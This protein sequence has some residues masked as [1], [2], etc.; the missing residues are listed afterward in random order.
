MKISIVAII[1]CLVF[2]GC[3]TETERTIDLS[4]TEY[5]IRVPE[6]YVP[7]E[8]LDQPAEVLYRT[9]IVPSVKL[10]NQINRARLED[11][12]EVTAT[13]LVGISG[14]VDDVL[15]ERSN[16]RVAEEDV[17]KA[18]KQWR[19]SQGQRSGEITKFFVR[20]TVF[21]SFPIEAETSNKPVQGTR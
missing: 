4:T 6:E 14:V 2:L 1:V 16:L 3:A 9:E 7:F 21:L 8:D 13:M 17:T 18:L 11:R 12:I 20:Q 5:S 10:L 15:I 19:F